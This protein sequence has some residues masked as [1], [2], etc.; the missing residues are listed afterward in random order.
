MCHKGDEN[1]FMYCNLCLEDGEEHQ[2]FKH[3]RITNAMKTFSQRWAELKENSENM[4]TN[5]TTYV[6]EF[7][8][9]IKY[10]DKLTVE[11]DSAL[12]ARFPVTHMISEDY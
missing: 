9:L 6:F 2:H 12:L 1:K 8:P 3:I 10:L 5:A 11:V 4:Y 7:L